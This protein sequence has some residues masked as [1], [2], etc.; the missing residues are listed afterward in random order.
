MLMFLGFDL[1]LVVDVVLTR[2]DGPEVCCARDFTGGQWL[3]VEIDDDPVHL[4]WLCAPISE[5]AMAAVVSGRASPMDAVR[6]S[7]TGTVELV[8]VVE[9]RA[10]PER[11]LLCSSVPEDLRPTPDRHLT[12]A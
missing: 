6:H 9:G 12:A 1:Q 4:A 10:M 5:R 2:Q 11:C 8:T 3:I 7:Q